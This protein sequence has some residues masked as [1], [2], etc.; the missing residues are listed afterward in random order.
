[1]SSQNVSVLTK[2]RDND[3]EFMVFSVLLATK[4]IFKSTVDIINLLNYNMGEMLWNG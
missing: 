2:N 1:M 4:K 3:T